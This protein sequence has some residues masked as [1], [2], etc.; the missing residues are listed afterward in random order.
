MAP[1]G[2][3]S[4]VMTITNE[5]A[6]PFTLALRADGTINALWHALQLGVWQAGTAAPTPL[7]ALLWWT[8]QSN[9]LATLQP[10]E[11]MRYEIEL[12]LPATATNAL[13][14]MAASIDLIWSAQG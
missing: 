12:Y 13:Q 4:E 6:A 5:T 8:N 14:G 3:A 9:P 7:P 10:G 11:S 2:A 1:G